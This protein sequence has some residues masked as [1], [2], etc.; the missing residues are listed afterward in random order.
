[1]VDE[2]S[3]NGNGMPEWD[4]LQNMWQD[5]PA[6]DMAK[7]ARS[8]RFVWWRMRVNFAVEIIMSIFGVGVFSM[9]IDFVSVPASM[10]GILGAL[11]CCLTFW[12]AIHIRRGAWDNPDKDVLSLVRLQIRR[13]KSTLL[14]I[15][16]NSWL[17]FAGILLLPLV[18]WV[19]YERFGT[20]DHDKVRTV[21]WVFGGLV[22]FVIAFPLILRPFTKRKKREISKLEEIEV[23]LENS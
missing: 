6:V 9:R 7:M 17:G 15:K 5:T 10:L 19:L 2:T 20:F 23:Q 14:Y 1:M 22:L 18:Y 4:D 16:L 8:A 12:A 21:N 11:Y 13:A 3:K